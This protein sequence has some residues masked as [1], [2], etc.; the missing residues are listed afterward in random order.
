MKKPLT[1]IASAGI[2]VVILIGVFAAFIAY[3]STPRFCG[4]CHIMETR[5]VSLRNSDHADEAS[6]IECHS[7]PGLIG[8]IEAHLVGS[9]YVYTYLTG[10]LSAP[11][12]LA[13]VPNENCFKCHEL[14]RLSKKPSPGEIHETYHTIHIEKELHCI[15][16]HGGLAHA[17]M[18]P[19]KARSAMTL[20]IRCHQ[21]GSQALFS[22]AQCHPT[23]P[24][25]PSFRSLAVRQLRKSQ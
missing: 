8:E 12:L 7:E 10:E 3:S 4:S 5:Y 14:T 6:C 21:T 20:C 24:S 17:T 15:G 16:C 1:W 19:V 13:E 25:G 23:G 2:V 22:C 9:R 11:I 18:L